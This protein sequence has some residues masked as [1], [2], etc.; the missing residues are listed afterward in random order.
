MSEIKNVVNLFEAPSRIKEVMAGPWEDIS[1][2]RVDGSPV[3]LVSDDTEHA[4]FVLGGVLTATN[5]SGEVFTLRK[6]SAFAVPQGGELTLSSA[7]AA[8]FL[9]VVLNVH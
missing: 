8:T 3:T 4:G 9:H 1:V 5:A 7:A 6:G 2:D